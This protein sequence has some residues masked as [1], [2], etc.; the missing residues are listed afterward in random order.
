MA[1]TYIFPSK[2]SRKPWSV[3]H[4]WASVSK[5]AACKQSVRAS[6]HTDS[7][8][9]ES[10]CHL[11]PSKGMTT[12]KLIPLFHTDRETDTQR[13]RGNSFRDSTGQ[14]IFGARMC[15]F[16]AGGHLQVLQGEDQEGCR[17]EKKNLQQDV[18]SNWG[19]FMLHCLLLFVT[20]R[21]VNIMS[22]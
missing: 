5:E 14:R 11:I 16:T 7:Y 2:N 9:H 4:F 13:V 3:L 22:L 18:W 21:N 1:A 12:C 8:I 20:Q 15:L 10:I 6:S 19:S 17:V